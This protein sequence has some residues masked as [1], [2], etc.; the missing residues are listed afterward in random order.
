MV[1]VSGF[2]SL[3]KQPENHLPTSSATPPLA[4]ASTA[5]RTPRNNHA[6]QRFD[7]RGSS[8]RNPQQH[9]PPILK[10]SPSRGMNG[11][12]FAGKDSVRINI[13][14]LPSGWGTWDIYQLL[15][16][17][18][19]L[20]KIEVLK[21][22][23]SSVCAYVVFCPPPQSADWITRGFVIRSLGKE[24]KVSFEIHDD[25][26]S[27]RGSRTDSPERILPEYIR[28][29]VL[30]V[31]VGVMSSETEMLALFQSDPNVRGTSVLIRNNDRKRLELFF[32]ATSHA[33]TAMNLKTFCDLSNVRSVQRHDDADGV[34]ILALQMEMPPQLFRKTDNVVGTHDRKV[35]LWQERQ[36]WFR[37][38]KIDPMSHDDEITKLGNTTAVLDFGRWLTY[39]LVLS[40]ATAASQTFRQI[41][42]VLHE[43]NVSIIVDAEPVHVTETHTKALWHWA[44]DPMGESLALSAMTSPLSTLDF[45][46][47]YH[48]DVCLSQ[49][50]LH[51]CNITVEFLEKLS[52]LEPDRAVEVLQIVA[53]DGKRY[54]NPM[55]IFRLQSQVSVRTRKIPSYCATIWLVTVTPAGVYIATPTVETSNRIIRKYKHI[56]DR[57]LRVRFSDERYKGKI[58]NGRDAA[59]NEIFTRIKRTM[60]NGID[61]AGRH[62]DFLAFGNS[63]FREHGAYFF[64]PTGN[65]TTQYILEHMGEFELIRDIDRNIA[66]YASRMGQ[67]FATTRGMSLG[68]Q[69]VKIDDVKRRGF[70]F[71]DGVGKISPFLAHSIATE[72][73]LSVTID[74]AP[75]VFQF[76]LGGCK[77][78]LAVDPSLK[79]RIVQIRPSQEKF[80]AKHHGL[81]IVRYSRFTSA[82]LNMQIILVLSAR[83]IEPFVFVRKMREALTEIAQAMIKEEHAFRQLCRKV[84]FNQTTITLA[85]MIHDGFMAAEDPYML[86]CLRLWKAW[87]TKYL[88][89]KARIF[90]DQGAFVLGCTDETGTLR[91]RYSDDPTKGELNEKTVLPEIFLQIS[92]PLNPGQ[93]LVIESICVLA[94]NPSLHP[95]DVLVVRAVDVPE[96]HHLR[97]CVALPQTGDRDL[98]NMCSGGDLDGDDFLVMWDPDLVPPEWFHEPMNY[99][100][101][102]PVRSEGSVSIDDITTF[103]VQHMRAD[104]LPLIACAHRYWAEDRSCPDGIKDDKCL[105]LAGLHSLAVDFPKTGVP[106][107]MDD[108]LIVKAW[109]HWAEHKGGRTYHSKKVIG[110]LY[111]LVRLED[112][113][114]AWDRPFDER[115][116]KAFQLD[117]DI[118]RT[119]RELK[120]L[121]D[122]AV[123]R[124]M[125]QFNINS[126]FEVMTTFVLSHNAAGSDYKLAEK[127][128]EIVS[129]LK[130]TH[131]D[132]CYEAASTT[133]QDQDWDKL[134]RFVAAMYTV[135]AHE[136]SDAYRASKQT[137]VRGGQ[138]VHIRPA[139]LK[140]MPF[141]SFPW[142]F[143]CELGHI[144]KRRKP[145]AGMF[146]NVPQLKRPNL[147]KLMPHFLTEDLELPQ[148]EDITTVDGVVHEGELLNV[149]HRELAVR[150]SEQDAAEVAKSEGAMTDRPRIPQQSQVLAAKASDLPVASA[151]RKN[152]SVEALH[153]SP[154]K[155]AIDRHQLEPDV[156][157]RSAEAEDLTVLDLQVLVPDQTASKQGDAKCRATEADEVG[158]FNV[159]RR[160][161]QQDG[162]EDVAEGEVVV[163]DGIN[164]LSSLDKLSKLVGG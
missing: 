21:H 39:R 104:N 120:L 8:P 57:F 134:S 76:R 126:D 133:R 80:P 123:R 154:V 91:G 70:C 98:A 100:S 71:T 124:V 27:Q 83:G 161:E 160:E 145:G 96:L 87:M 147:T 1:P 65:I 101:P 140:N 24:H 142:L 2:Q 19:N 15:T 56:E 92:D 95:G 109:P 55:E 43:S 49:H 9:R 130:H 155:V 12:P 137:E 149:H 46:V 90:V 131:Q 144:A 37:Q 146:R 18:G 116:L 89:E 10:T 132:M 34:T 3:L 114:P 121:Y 151:I 93:Y 81:E 157:E 106:A 7:K 77:G 73:K 66:K 41:G 117:N 129:A 51:E 150:G 75:S 159:R 84:D 13:K 68:A 20:F 162:D 88:K 139:T 141:M 11:R 38:T 53:D 48:L 143:S 153:A 42:A 94:R 36:A 152:K 103:F 148:L 33:N 25:P 6:L 22:T 67:C 23:A 47:R 97:D 105:R 4:M 72:Y 158:A 119:A 40:D 138:R 5:S 62:Y 35:F 85:N 54:F 102:P 136:V 63:Q 107:S 50:V 135:T 125:V 69:I 163:L 78:V 16:P 127:L 128:G 64:A 113:Q 110:Q 79:G 156:R 82:Y 30:Q 52:T 31:Q 60:K 44:E 58:T 32:S 86:S 118:L 28:L 61:I 26:R 164:Q 108:D 112:F 115:I 17:Y 99:E 122:A 45:K 59:E 14:M 74:N 111:D 29:P